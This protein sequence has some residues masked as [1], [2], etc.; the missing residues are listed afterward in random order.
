[1]DCT[2]QMT[3]V[4]VWQP[5]VRMGNFAAC[6]QKEPCGD[7]HTGALREQDKIVTAQNAPIKRALLFAPFPILASML[8]KRR[9]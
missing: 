1:M 8:P 7:N 5:S 9:G 2:W 6:L 3:L 4:S